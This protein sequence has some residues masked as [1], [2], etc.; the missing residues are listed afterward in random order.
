MNE[1]TTGEERSGGMSWGC[2]VPPL[3]EEGMRV[4]KWGLN[5][6]GFTVREAA[7]MLRVPLP[8]ARRVVD[9]LRALQLV[10]SLPGEP[11]RLVPANPDLAAAGVLAPIEIDILSRQRSV[12]RL[13]DAL[14]RLSPLYQA[15]RSGASV[16]EVVDVVPDAQSV[17]CLLNEW[18]VRCRAEVLMVQPGGGRSADQLREAHERDLQM[19]ERGIR[20]RTLYQH[21]ARFDLP[22]REHIR[23]LRE[24]GADIR[25]CE[26]LFSY[27]VVFDDEVAFIP[28]ATGSGGAAVIRGSATIGFLRGVFEHIWT[29]AKPFVPHHLDDQAVTDEIKQTILNMLTEGVKDDI[30]ARRLGLSVRTCRKHIAQLMRQMDAQSRFQFGYLAGRGGLTRAGRTPA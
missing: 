20:M 27:L 3:S 18:A 23:T 9:E 26:V 25:T 30:I 14:T 12:T 8:E 21:S 17:R 2:G 24:A 7:A 15:S 22:I 10:Q 13:R 29:T 19:L 28:A 11:D 16:E 5:G 6:D 4:Y 1:Q